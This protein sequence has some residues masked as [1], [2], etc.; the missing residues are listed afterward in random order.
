MYLF[1]DFIAYVFLYKKIYFMEKKWTP[2]SRKELEK[3]SYFLQFDILFLFLGIDQSLSGNYTCLAKNLYGS[4]SVVFTVKVL[5]LPDP[6]TLRATP[7]KD[8][9]VVEWDEIR[10][11]G[12]D[13]V[14]FGIS[15]YL[16]KISKYL[17]NKDNFG[18]VAEQFYYY[19]F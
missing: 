4:D 6:P 15:K 14:G 18:T 13:S 16:C 11:Y 2:C 12:N 17:Y 1:I 8:Y 7:Y 3:R 5:P 19:R 9:I 10:S